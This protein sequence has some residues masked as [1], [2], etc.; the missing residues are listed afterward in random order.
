MNDG[1]RHH[2]ETL[3]AN[4]SE[5]RATVSRKTL[6]QA[7]N[8]IRELEKLVERLSREVVRRGN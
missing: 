3:A 6:V 2:L 7:M 8:Y 5:P 1:I 4:K